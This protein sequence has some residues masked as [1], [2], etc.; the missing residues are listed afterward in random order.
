MLNRICGLLSTAAVTLGNPTVSAVAGYLAA[1]MVVCGGSVVEITGSGFYGPHESISVTVNAVACTSVVRV[2][3]TTIRCTLPMG[4]AYSVA[5][6]VVV[7]TLG[8]SDTLVGG[9]TY[10]ASPLTLTA[11]TPPSGDETDAVTLTGTGFLD[12]TDV[13]GNGFSLAVW[14]IVNDRTITCTVE[15]Q[16]PPKPYD[17]TLS[18]FNGVD[19]V[20][21]TYRVG[22]VISSSAP[23]TGPLAGGTALVLTGVGFTGATDVLFQGL[24]GLGDPA[25]SGTAL[26]VVSDTEIHV[27]SPDWGSGPSGFAGGVTLSVV[28]PYGTFADD[29]SHFAYT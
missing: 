25:M 10:V 24:S 15:P 28:L 29:G 13:L 18:V 8:G 16:G 1:P 2:N 7:T 6:D 12:A 3:T 9:L 27:T 4:A 26:T 20:N 22:A 11:V 19:T 23:T 5:Y 17:A 14:A 21:A